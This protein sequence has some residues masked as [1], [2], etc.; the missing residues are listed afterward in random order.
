MERVTLRRSQI[1]GFTVRLWHGLSV[2]VVTVKHI[3]VTL[4]IWRGRSFIWR[5]G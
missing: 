2:E 3:P 4:A 1:S 5:V